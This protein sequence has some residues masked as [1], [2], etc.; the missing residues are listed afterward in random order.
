LKKCDV[1]VLN[2]TDEW[3]IFVKGFNYEIVEK[4]KGILALAY[5]KSRQ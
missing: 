1:A 3:V 2:I 4:G 5:N